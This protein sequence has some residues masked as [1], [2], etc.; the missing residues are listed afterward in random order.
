MSPLQLA[1]G[2]GIAKT[3]T[4]LAVLILPFVAALLQPDL[5]G[6]RITITESD[7]KALDGEWIYLEDLTEGRALEQMTPPMGGKFTFKTEEGAVILVWGHGGARRDVKV[8][9]NGSVTEFSTQ[10]PGEI[11]RYRGAVKD[12]AFSYEVEYLNA[13][14]ETRTL[15][16]REFL[17]TVEGLIV[18]SNLGAP[19]EYASV[20]L[21]KQAKDISMPTP[22]KATISDISWLAGNWAGSRGTNG[23]ISFE[24]LWSPP[25]GGAMLA[26]SRTVSRDRMSAFEYLRIVERDGGLTYFAQPNGAEAT[27]FVMTEISGKRAVFD[28]PRH[29][30][31]KRIIY[32]LTETGGM[33]ATI[34]YMKGGTP[35]KFEFKRSTD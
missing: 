12:G 20:G 25:K 17:P 18:R 11:V 3:S 27:E 9:L 1:F 2:Q 29:D 34:G 6:L 24:E 16:R 28:N 30:Y 5:L 26:I 10:T 35:R 32:E 13:A 31:P 14:G 21:Y 22:V 23:S 7:L 33:T 15:I 8:A 19:R 4:A